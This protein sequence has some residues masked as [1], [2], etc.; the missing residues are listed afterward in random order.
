MVQVIEESD[1]KNSIKCLKIPLRSKEQ[2]YLIFL[3][4]SIVHCFVYVLHFSADLVVAVQH[5]KENNSMWAFI[6][7]LFIYAPAL[8]YFILTISR[9]D[10]W[11]TDYDK[12]YKGIFLWLLLQLGKLIAFP[13][14]ALYR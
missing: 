3:L 7:I 1:H 5:F 9:P 13:F 14:F 10:W 4:P 11:M 2:I 6:T 8:V 12:M